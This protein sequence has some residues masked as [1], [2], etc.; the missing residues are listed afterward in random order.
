MQLL[1]EMCLTYSISTINTG[2]RKRPS[3][4]CGYIL[5]IV[6]HREKKKDLKK[7]CHQNILSQS[8]NKKRQH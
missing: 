4:V 6:C 1:P 2:K 7:I 5:Y 8:F 3:V